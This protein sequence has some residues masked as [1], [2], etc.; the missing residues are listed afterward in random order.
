MCG[1]VIDVSSLVLLLSL[2]ETKEWWD[3]RCL[4]AK[5]KVPEG[6]TVFQHIQ[7]K[8]VVSQLLLLTLDFLSEIQT[9][10]VAHTFVG[11]SANNGC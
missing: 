9:L 2:Q 4:S 6:R 10:N 5:E 3:V 1:F 8:P 11:I 7:T